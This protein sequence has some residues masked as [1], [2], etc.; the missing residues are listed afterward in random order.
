[1]VKIM[2]IIGSTR[3][4]RGGPAVADWI[5]SLSKDHTNAEFE[6]VDLKEIN[7]PFLDEPELPSAHH[8]VQE[9][10]KKWSAMV[11][12]ADGFVWVHPE[13]NHGVNAALKNALDFIWQEWNDK[14]VA[15]VGYGSAAGGAR[16]GEQLRLIAAGLKMFDLRADIVLPN[17]QQ[18]I[19]DGTFVAS[20][21]HT[22]A[23]HNILKELIFW[24]AH[25]QQARK[26][27]KML[28]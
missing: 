12:S 18:Y 4:N 13:Y 19:K 10:T 26:D 7:L 16:A 1:M 23:A 25:M 11:D 24:A 5:M 2:V 27:L 17:Y 20:E 14:P 28:Q 22:K 9:H 8:Y 21:G 15:L 6:L 3:P